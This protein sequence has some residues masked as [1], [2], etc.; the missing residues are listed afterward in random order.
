MPEVRGEEWWRWWGGDVGQAGRRR[1]TIMGVAV[2]WCRL[3]HCHRCGAVCTAIRRLTRSE[4]PP[5]SDC[6]L[7]GWLLS[8]T[9]RTTGRR[10]RR[11][12]AAGC[13]STPARG[14]GVAVVGD[15]WG[16]ERGTLHC[17]AR[18]SPDDY[19]LSQMPLSWSAACNSGKLA[20]EP[21]E[22][23]RCEQCC[24]QCCEQ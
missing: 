15:G 9:P 5:F 20:T 8:V 23:S 4:S 1:L 19:P 18:A 14:P 12:G 11:G 22:G 2:C 10:P 6:G 24:E 3:V 17:Q 21:A 16:Q 13:G 7:A